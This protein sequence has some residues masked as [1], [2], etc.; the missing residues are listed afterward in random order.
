MNK[1]FYHGD[2]CL[3]LKEGTR[4]KISCSPAAHSDPV[5]GPFHV[6]FLGMCLLSLLTQEIRSSPTCACD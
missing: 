3:K 2:E 1:L 4:E 6:Y 5:L